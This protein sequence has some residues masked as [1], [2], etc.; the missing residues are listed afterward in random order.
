MSSL[1]LPS[2][3][4]GPILAR[5]AG[6]RRVLTVLLVT[7]VTF[8]MTTF[9]A[10]T[11]VMAA[12]R[13]P[14]TLTLNISSADLRPGETIWF[15]GMLTSNGIALGGH[16]VELQFRT[17][18]GGWRTVQRTTVARG[19]SYEFAVRPMELGYYRTQYLGTSANAPVARGSVGYSWGAGRRSLEVRAAQITSAR[20]GQRTSDII[21]ARSGDGIPIR[22]NT[23]RNG[24]L[25]EY[26]TGSK[27]RTFWVTGE[28]HNQYWAHGGPTGKLGVPIL[29]VECGL[30][31]NG[32]L[33]R[34]TGGS[35][36]TSDTA[37]QT[38]VSLTTGQQS[39]MIAVAMSQVGYKAPASNIS[40]YN[41]WMGTNYAWC[42]IFLSWVTAASGN[43]YVIPGGSRF[44]YFHKNA[45]AM[46]RTSSSPSIG[47]IA[48]FDTHLYNGARNA[49]THAGLVY[50]YNSRYI[51]TIE[52]NTSP[53][54]GTS[55]RGV[56]LKKRLRTHPLYYV[57][58]P[59]GS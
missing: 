6:I 7:A 35:V 44:S 31:D 59:Y 34:F 41:H 45:L 27:I 13:A 49:A 25:V 50:G 47:A 8:S 10:P 40:R 18:S 55:G 53:T 26:G 23:Y 36:Y 48:F 33:H 57:H 17:T 24:T 22:Y 16:T 56:F 19:G 1:L 5:M 12:T 29:D 9:T 3:P 11:P 14:T 30:M 37:R 28:A 38:G 54:N 52:G 4:C 2:V 43:G 58:P 15:Y 32:C 39:E 46:G 20:L 21:T 42:S 51:W